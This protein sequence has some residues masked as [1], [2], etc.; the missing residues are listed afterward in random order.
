MFPAEALKEKLLA[1]LFQ[2]LELPRVYSLS[3]GPFLR[4]QSQEGSIL[5][6]LSHLSLLQSNLPLPSSYEDTS[7]YIWGHPDNPG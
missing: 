7:D 2:L 1:C 4:P 5:L 6:Q 3:Q